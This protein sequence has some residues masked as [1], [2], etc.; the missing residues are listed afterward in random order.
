[1]YSESS[2]GK[3]TGKMSVQLKSSQKDAEKILW[4]AYEELSPCITRF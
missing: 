3:F 2:F 4:Q 1:M